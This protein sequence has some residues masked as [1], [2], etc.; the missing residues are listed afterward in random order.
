MNPHF[1]L[2]KYLGYLNHNEDYTPEFKESHF[3]P[4]EFAT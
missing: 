3:F 4:R 2:L 1:S